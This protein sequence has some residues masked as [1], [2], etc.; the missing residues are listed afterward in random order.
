MPQPNAR[1]DRTTSESTLASQMSLLKTLC[2]LG[3]I[4]FHAA[5]SFT[6]PDPGGFWKIYADRQSEVAV[7]FCFWGGLII[8]P[9]FM[10]ASGYLSA[11]SAERRRRSVPAYIADRAKRLLVPWFLLTVVWMVPLYT[12]FD[13]PVYNR[14]EGYILAQTYLVGLTGL[15]TDHLWFLLVLFW[16]SVFFAAL[17]PLANRLGGL[18]VP[19]LA[20]VAA[21]LVNEYGHLLTWYALWETSGPLIWFGLGTVLCRYRNGIGKALAR[22]P[23]TLTLFGLN[24]VLFVVTALFVAQTT[25]IYWL[26]CCLGALTA[27]QVC[28][29]LARFHGRLRGFW[30]YRYFEDNALRFYLFHMPGVY[31]TYR[32]LSAAGLSSPLPLMLISFACNL[33]LTACLVAV[34]NTLR[35]CLAKIFGKGIFA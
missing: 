24:L 12:L 33:C 31:L 27:F 10:L 25:P 6:E 14:P 4:F 26:T 15:F 1:A 28:L 32:T 16:V 23:L 30:P 3:V 35:K 11:L 19:A 9:S 29:H 34:F 21:L 20:L 13:I 7:F 17:R 5:F 18:L 2:L 8:I 22:R